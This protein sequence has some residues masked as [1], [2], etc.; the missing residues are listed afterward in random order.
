MAYLSIRQQHRLANYS[1][2][3]SRLILTSARDSSQHRF[4]T[5]PH[6]GSQVGNASAQ[7]LVRIGLA[8]RNRIASTRLTAHWVHIGP[9]PLGPHRPT[10]ARVD[11]GRSVHV[12]P[13][14]LRRPRALGPN[15]PTGARSTSAHGRSVHTGPRAL[16]PHLSGARSHICFGVRHLSS[17]VVWPLAAPSVFCFFAGTKNP[18]VMNKFW[19]RVIG[20]LVARPHS[21]WTQGSSPSPAPQPCCFSSD[22]EGAVCCYRGSMHQLSC[23]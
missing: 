18:D 14:A 9:Q 17:L 13:R 21:R 22:L 11:H 16:G 8:I 15:R 20:H 5:R 1:H 3:S 7:I 10:G 23:R 6:I 19:Q 12:G 2:I 4:G